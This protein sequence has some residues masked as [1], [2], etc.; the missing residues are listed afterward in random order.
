MAWVKKL[1]TA[2]TTI[3]LG[4]IKSQNRIFGL[5]KHKIQIAWFRR[6]NK[7][8]V[9]IKQKNRA[10]VIKD[11]DQRRKK[12][13]L[14]CLSPYASNILRVWF[15]DFSISCTYSLDFLLWIEMFCCIT[16]EGC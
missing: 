1:V 14:H 3:I 8:N 6:K 10:L 9:K 4:L 16:K 12:T 5:S 11:L 7:I 15:Q 13:F 2:E